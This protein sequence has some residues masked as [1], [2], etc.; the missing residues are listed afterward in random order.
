MKIMKKNGHEGTVRKVYDNEHTKVIAV[1]GTVADLLKEG[2]LEYCD[3]DTSF[4]L[5]ISNT[6][7][8][9]HFGKTRD[10]ALEPFAKA[11]Y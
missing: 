7:V 11:G 10:E 9:D 4:W 2:L 6:A 3:C 8:K 1:V 5:A